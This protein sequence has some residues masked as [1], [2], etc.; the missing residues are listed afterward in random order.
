[1][2]GSNKLDVL[3]AFPSLS[4]IAKWPIPIGGG[5]GGVTTLEMAAEAEAS[6]PSPL[7]LLKMLF[8]LSICLPPFP[9]MDIY[10]GLLRLPLHFHGGRAQNAIEFLFSSSL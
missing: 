1:M 8:S 5:G 6:I 4:C 7:F 3:T 9:E 10:T 2:A